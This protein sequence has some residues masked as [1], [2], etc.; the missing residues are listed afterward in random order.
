MSDIK[1]LFDKA[2]EDRIVDQKEASTL[3]KDLTAEDWRKLAAEHNYS[4]VFSP[5]DLKIE[6]KETE[7]LIHNDKDAINDRKILDGV[8]AFGLAIAAPVVGYGVGAIAARFVANVPGPYM[9]FGAAAL[10]LALGVWNYKS[11]M[12]GLA[13]LEQTAFPLHIRKDSLPQAKTAMLDHSS[14]INQTL[15]SQRPSQRLS[16]ARLG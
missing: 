7:F 5:T 6:E 9:K 1:A 2:T 11:T 13:E 12:S 16:L 15:M 14:A 4:G 10:G 8:K 3:L